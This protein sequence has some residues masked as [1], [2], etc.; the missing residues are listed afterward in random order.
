M[1]Y[2]AALYLEADNAGTFDRDD[3]VDFMILKVIG[4]PLARYEEVVG[5]ELIDEC[6]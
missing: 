5:L 3:E 6:R 1:P 4:D 2:L